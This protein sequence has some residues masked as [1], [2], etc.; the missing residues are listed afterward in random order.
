MS[1]K[2]RT[3][4]ITTSVIAE[5]RSPMT[6]MDTNPAMM[7]PIPH[8]KPWSDRIFLWKGSFLDGCFMMASFSWLLS[9]D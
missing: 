1:R 3:D 9:A 5:G 6:N 7:R 8:P 4:R 2:G